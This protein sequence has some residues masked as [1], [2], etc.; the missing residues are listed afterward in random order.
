MSPSRQRGLEGLEVYR[1]GGAVRDARLGWPTADTDW[2]VVGATPA[3]MQ[4]RGFRPVGRDFPVF[5]HPETHEEYALARTERKS[6]HGYTGF[7]VHASPDVTLEEDLARRDLTINAMAETPEGELVDPYGGLADL[8]AGLLRHVSPAFVEDPLRVLRTARFLARYARLG[9]AIADETR[10]LMRQ[11][12]ASG[13]LAHLVAE[14]VW[15]ETEKALGEADPAVYFRTLH[16][17]H[18]LAVLMPELVEDRAAFERALARL[19]RLPDRVA[20]EERPRWRWARL[21]EH[22]D[23]TRQ[24]AL[25]ERLRLPRRYRDLGRQAALTRRLRQQASPGADDV[26]EWLDGIDA[27]RRGERVPPLIALLALDA[28]ALA[29]TLDR[30]WRA[31]SQLDAKHLFG[32]GFRGGA[33]GQE[34]ARRRRALLARELA[35]G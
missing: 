10:A 12:A 17:C 14:R 18:A 31:V 29:E 25:A 6:G 4:R 7:E 11:L 24:E 3:E 13:E 30:A 22:L 19:A 23:D 34:L 16:E 9:F 32:E 35:G 1:V 21:V 15:T 5:L 8:R 33:L 2:V 20:D 27:W 26:K 28:P